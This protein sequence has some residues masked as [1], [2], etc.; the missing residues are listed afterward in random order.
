MKAG[1]P[2]APGHVLGFKGR[3]RQREAGRAQREETE[4]GAAESN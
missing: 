2:A 3:K 1:G 4:N